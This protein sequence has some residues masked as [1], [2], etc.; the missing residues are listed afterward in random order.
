MKVEHPIH[1]QDYRDH[2]YAV[3]CEPSSLRPGKWLVWVDIFEGGAGGQG[4]LLMTAEHEYTFTS[5]EEGTQGGK[6][7]A[8]QLIDAES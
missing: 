5:Q 4:T 7:L 1:T 8:E 6:K 2:S 3:H